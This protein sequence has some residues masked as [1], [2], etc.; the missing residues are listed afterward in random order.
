VTFFPNDFHQPLAS[1]IMT[2]TDR[3]QRQRFRTPW[4]QADHGY[5]SEADSERGFM[6]LAED[7][8]RAAVDDEIAL[9]DIAPSLL[10]LLGEAP[11]ATMRGRSVF[12]RRN[13]GRSA[14][15]LC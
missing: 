2:L 13:S 12:G 5:P 8:Y 9:V 1:L 10:T 14:S 4:H 7:G 11:A 3:Q 6:L 15:L